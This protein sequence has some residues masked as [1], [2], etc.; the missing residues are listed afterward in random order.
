M[1][2]LATAGRVL[3]FACGIT[4]AVTLTLVAVLAVWVARAARREPRPLPRRAPFYV[5]P[6][7]EFDEGIRALLED[8]RE[9]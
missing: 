3:W 9:R 1:P 5:L 6:E 8:V 4:G 2:I 7:S